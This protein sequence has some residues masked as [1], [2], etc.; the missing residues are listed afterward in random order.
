MGKSGIVAVCLVFASFYL[1]DG[2]HISVRTW[3]SVFD[4][5]PLLVNGI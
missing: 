2:V 1:N 3:A 5:K 4:V